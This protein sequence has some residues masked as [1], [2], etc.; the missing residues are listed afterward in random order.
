MQ[1]CHWFSQRR[2]GLTCASGKWLSAGEARVYFVPVRDSRLA[3]LPA[4]INDAVSLKS[5]KVNE[6][7]IEVLNLDAHL[8]H[9]TNYRAH[10]FGVLA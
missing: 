9:V 7:R 2:A 8:I 6:R 10:A 5:G 3:L 4:K 1:L